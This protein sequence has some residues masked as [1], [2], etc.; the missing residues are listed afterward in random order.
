MLPNLN[1]F[2]TSYFNSLPSA[3]VAEEA[4]SKNLLTN[5]TLIAPIFFKHNMQDSWGLALLHRHWDVL[6]GEVP[7]QEEYIA[8]EFKR[9]ITSPKKSGYNKEAWPYLMA[10]TSFLDHKI[11]PLEFAT[12]STTQTRYNEL[13]AKQDFIDELC[14]ILSNNDLLNTFGI[15]Q[16]KDTVAGYEL[17]ED[18]SEGR[19]SIISAI[20]TEESKKE[21]L[22]K[23]SWFFSADVNGMQCTHHS[24]RNCPW[25]L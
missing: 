8:G 22:I 25:P 18:T 1:H 6:D 19:I 20:P 24:C 7:V 11:Q 16:A 4:A 17:I 12:S 3:E 5:L 14:D 13:S 10:L 23:T 9:Y 2:K 21:K 15:V